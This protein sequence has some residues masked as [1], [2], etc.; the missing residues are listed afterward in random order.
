M[1]SFFSKSIKKIYDL[2]VLNLVTEYKSDLLPDAECAQKIKN[3]ATNAWVGFNGFFC[4]YRLEEILLEIGRRHV[5]T[6]TVSR[7]QGG[8][9]NVLHVASSLGSI[10]G[11]TRVLLDWINTDLTSDHSLFLTDQETV[12][13]WLADKLIGHRVYNNRNQNLIEKA[14]KLNRIS[15]EFDLII[16]HHHPNDVV[17][18][19]AFAANSTV[20]LF[21]YNHADHVFWLGSSIAD[22]IIEI[23]DSELSSKYRNNGKGIKL[24]FVVE[25]GL[26]IE[27]SSAKREL[28]ISPNTVVLLSIGARYKFLP[29]RFNYIKEIIIPLLRLHPY[30]VYYLIGPDIEFVEKHI[31]RDIPPN[32]I[33]AGYITD[34]VMYLKASDIY[35]E[36][37]PIGSGLASLEAMGFGSAPLFSKCLAI[38][39]GKTNA[40]GILNS[41]VIGSIVPENIS[42]YRTVLNELVTDNK[43]RDTFAQKSREVVE[44]MSRDAWNSEISKLYNLSDRLKHE[45]S[46]IRTLSYN[47][48]SEDFIRFTN[49]RKFV[50]EF[51]YRGYPGV[52]SSLY[53]IKLNL[54][55]LMILNFLFIFTI[56]LYSSFRSLF[57]L[58]K[59][60]LYRLYK[61]VY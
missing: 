60:F 17:P 30:L 7:R 13:D 4:D 8:R 1:S 57:M 40:A 11:H 26:S 56:G 3:I 38:E 59:I 46:L 41:Q 2:Q 15:R 20:P 24:P 32:L 25:N 37:A 61:G 18:L 31:S 58:N 5:E 55:D 39:P 16:L 21:I 53:D 14:V 6:N 47:S 35:I 33:A 12:P 43:I 22:C 10:G 9:R 48:D 27:K 44:S 23:R 45:P 52:Y 28:G 50:R 51:F 36:S 49:S 42:E 19:I 54:K 34:P 29:Y